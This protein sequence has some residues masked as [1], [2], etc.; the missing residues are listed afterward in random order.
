[1]YHMQEHLKLSKL[2][3]NMWFDIEYYKWLALAEENDKFAVFTFEEK[4]T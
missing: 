4:S 2:R 1:M 3:T